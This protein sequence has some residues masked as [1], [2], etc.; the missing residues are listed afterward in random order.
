VENDEDLIWADEEPDDDTGNWK[1][2]LVI[3]DDNE[4][5]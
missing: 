2:K 5:G 3:D 4:F 1:M